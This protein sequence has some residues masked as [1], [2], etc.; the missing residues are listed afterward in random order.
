MAIT[1]KRYHVAFSNEIYQAT[2]NYVIWKMLQTE[3]AKDEKLLKA[4]NLSPLSWIFIRHS[5]IFSLIMALGRIFD[6]DSNS[7]SIFALIKS[8]IE[9]IDLFSKVKL[10]ERKMQISGAEEWIDEYMKTVHE[11]CEKDFQILRPEI[12]R[13]KEIYQTY[14]RPVRHKILA[15]RDKEQYENSHELWNAINK[16]NIEGML[17]FLEDINLTIRDS[18]NDGKKLELKGRKI[19]EQWFAKDILFLLDRVKN[20]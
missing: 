13:Y 16:A 10:K 6:T 8:C 11:P 4:L 19:D 20:A 14:L 5:M 9:N 12:N 17:N 1:F 7:F 15:H 18:F 2:A 3:A